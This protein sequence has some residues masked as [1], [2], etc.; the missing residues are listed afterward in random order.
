MG[1][2]AFAC[3]VYLLTVARRGTLDLVWSLLAFRKAKAWIR[4]AADYVDKLVTL[5]SLPDLKQY[6]ETVVSILVPWGSG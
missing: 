3:F 1:A 5:S 2:S 6:L 4:Y